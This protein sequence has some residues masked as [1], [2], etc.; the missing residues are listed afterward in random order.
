MRAFFGRLEAPAYLLLRVVA[1]ALFALHG[2]QKLLGLFGGQVMPAFSLAWFAGVIELGAGASI[3]VGL[4]TRPLAFLASGEMAFAF[5]IGHVKG[6]FSF[7]HLLP[8]VNRGELAVLYCFLF[9][10]VCGHGGGVASLDR[11]LRLGT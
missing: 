2:G 1:G 4:L 7:P 3:A 9:L 6:D 10:Y 8:L 11:R 5:F